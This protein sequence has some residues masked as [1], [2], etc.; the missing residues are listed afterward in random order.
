MALIRT[1][2]ILNMGESSKAVTIPFGHTLTKNDKLTLVILNN[3]IL[4]IEEDYPRD[5]LIKDLEE[6]ISDI[7][8]ITT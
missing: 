5:K 4:L 1:R 6:L 7:N 3:I 2:S 8:K